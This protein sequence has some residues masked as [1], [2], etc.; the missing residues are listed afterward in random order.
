MNPD[1]G[2]GRPSSER[3]MRLYIEDGAI[4]AEFFDQRMGNGVEPRHNFIEKNARYVE[5]LEM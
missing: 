1:G 4:A 5:N 3:L 2:G